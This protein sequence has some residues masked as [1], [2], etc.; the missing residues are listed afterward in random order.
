MTGASA[1]AP[2]AEPDSTNLPV[3][4]EVYTAARAAYPLHRRRRQCS[5]QD[6]ES[7]Y[8][9]LWVQLRHA[10]EPVRAIPS[11]AEAD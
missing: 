11:E 10:G 3:P 8:I 6:F 1:A 7:G 5:Y 9:A 2:T 4:V